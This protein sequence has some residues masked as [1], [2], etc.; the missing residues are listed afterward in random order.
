MR[1]MS[2]AL[3]TPQV[4]ARTKDVTRRMGWLKLKAGDLVQ[5]VKKCMGLKPGEKIEKLGPPI[6]I[7]SVHREPLSQMTKDLEYGFEE[8]RREGFEGH[9]AYQWPSEWVQMFCAT[10]KGCTPDT[11]VTRIE[12]TWEE[13]S[14]D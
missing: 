6:R 7:I 4:L 13:C 14:H 9:P 2:F 5:P 11:M 12:F 3:T 8:V 10:H 1:N